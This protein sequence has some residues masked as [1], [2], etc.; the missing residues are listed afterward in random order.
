MT[1]REAADAIDSLRLKLAGGRPWNDHTAE[2]DALSAALQAEDQ[3]DAGRPWGGQCDFC[4][5]EGYR[6]GLDEGQ[7]ALSQLNDRHETTKRMLEA[8]RCA[9]LQGACE[10]LD[11]EVECKRLAGHNRLL[12]REYARVCAQRNKLTDAAKLRQDLA[13][14]DKTIAELRE[15]SAERM[16]RLRDQLAKVEAHVAGITRFN[17]S[18]ARC[19]EALKK[20][21][22]GLTS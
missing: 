21:G 12:N 13:D 19:A 15:T 9:V 16:I 8:A 20:L 18:V 1:K 7:L 3:A 14:R 11:L 10:R 22:T 5:N 17:E 4:I 2:S 6:K